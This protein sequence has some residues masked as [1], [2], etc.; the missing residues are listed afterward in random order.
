VYLFPARTLGRFW[1]WLSAWGYFIANIT[2][3]AFS[4]IYVGVYLSVGFPV[5]AN[6]QVPLALAAILFCFILNVLRINTASRANF[7]LTSLLAVT[8]LIFVITAFA[9]GKWDSSLLRPFFTQGANGPVG[10]IS[11]VPTAMVA[12]G[13][14]VTAA[15]MVSEL[16]TPGKNV[17]R[18]MLTATAITVLLYLLVLLA[19]LGLVPASYLAENPG[20]RFIPLYAACFNKLQNLPWLAGLLSIAAVLALLT[21]ILIVMAVTSRAL[22]AAADKSDMGRLPHT[23]S[24]TAGS[25]PTFFAHRTKNGT[26]LP[27]LALLTLPSVVVACFPQ[28]TQEIVNLGVLS[29]VIGNALICASF[30]AE[31]RQGL[32]Q[33]AVFRTPG[34]TVMAVIL[35]IVFALCYIPGIVSGGWQLWA[36]TAILYTTGVII[37]ALGRRC[38]CCTC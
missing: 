23:G 22:L 11:A 24:Q 18:A 6:L 16:K 13:Q 33:K 5:F 26:P 10:F 38:R 20:M 29:T 34:G 2:S 14:I 30:L 15:F 17:P 9:S 25:L 36:Y 37:Y 28:F 8:L 1:G 32:R 19:T 35:L 4:A 12:Y 3:I 21:T 7:V 27:A 31:G